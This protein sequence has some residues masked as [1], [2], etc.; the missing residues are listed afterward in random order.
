MRRVVWLT[1]IHLNFLQPAQIAVLE[2]A[3][4][5]ASP[6]AMLV[7]GDIAEA[8][9]LPAYL[10]GMSERLPVPVYF[11]L[12]NHDFYRGSVASVRR[13]VSEL[14]RTLPNLVYLTGSEVVELTPSVGL[15]GH[16]GW[17]DGRAGHYWTSDV[18]LN[19]YFLIADLAEPLTSAQRF[20]RLNQFGDEASDH[21]RRVLPPALERY[22]EVF[23]L[24]HVPPFREACWH[25]GR[26]SDDNWSPHF[27]CVAMGEA[28]REIAAQR[29]DRQITV[30]CG[31]T[32]SPGEARILDNLVVVTGGAEYGCPA[33][34]RVFEFD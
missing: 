14:C 7:G 20:E 19:D 30:L 26:T 22:R 32:H 34:Q 10:R 31:H 12:G 11:V 28:L 18:F 8:H 5:C 25:E 29:P 27:V 15:V 4:L 13:M 1:D 21:I 6:D 17:A 3:I 9:N 33:I 2:D 24:T 23:V 16:D